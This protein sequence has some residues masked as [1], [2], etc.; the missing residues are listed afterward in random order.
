MNL[1]EHEQRDG[2]KVWL[3]SAELDQ[4]IDTAPNASAAIAFALAG[5]CG[6][7]SQEV[8]DV[9]PKDIKR[10]DAGPIVRVVGKGDKYR[11][12]WL[13]ESLMTQIKTAAAFRDEPDHFPIVQSQGD[14]MKVSTRTLR[15]W[16]ADAAAELV[17]E[18]DED[19]WAQVSFHDLRRSWATNLAA[20]GVDPILVLDVGGWNDLETFLDH[21]RGS[22]S[23]EAHRREREKVEWL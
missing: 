6:L 16:I 15:R 4:L 10:T 8:A 11:E 21:Y 19:A 7:R 12:A 1:R 17:T 23:P 2:F 20:A 22:Y 3:S 13:P 14:S 9:T 18:T 5:R